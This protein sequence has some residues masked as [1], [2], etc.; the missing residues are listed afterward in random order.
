MLFSIKAIEQIL[1]KIK[2]TLVK[3]Q[4]LLFYFLDLSQTGR[5]TRCNM[6]AINVVL[7]FLSN[8]D[9]ELSD[10]HTFTSKTHGFKS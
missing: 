4:Q 7:I 6:S 5:P 1:N 2:R 8:G 3:K 9:E 10:G